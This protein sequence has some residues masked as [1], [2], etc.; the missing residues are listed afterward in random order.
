MGR[1][2][3]LMKKLKSEKKESEIEKTLKELE[4]EGT[5]TADE[6]AE[7]MGQNEDRTAFVPKVDVP[8]VNLE[9]FTINEYGEIIREDKKEKAK[10]EDTERE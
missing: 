6:I 4:D 2:E 9:G 7:T 5:R 8:P 3:N 1:L 10:E